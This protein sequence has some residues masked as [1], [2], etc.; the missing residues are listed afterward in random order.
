ME[1]KILCHGKG[2]GMYVFCSA[3]VI[4]VS[5][6]GRT[7]AFSKL[8]FPFVDPNKTDSQDVSHVDVVHFNNGLL[9]VVNGDIVL[10]EV[11]KLT[12]GPDKPGRIPKIELKIKPLRYF[13]TGLASLQKQISHIELGFDCGLP[14]FLVIARDKP[15]L[16]SSTEERYYLS[17]DKPV[18]N[19]FSFSI[20]RMTFKCQTE[21]D[22]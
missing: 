11:S 13:K 16:P 14:F 17:D 20:M 21:F 22:Y 15:K 12:T 9:L 1:K 8:E 10:A 4:A 18:S 7:W 6:N 5:W 2:H 19:P 3:T